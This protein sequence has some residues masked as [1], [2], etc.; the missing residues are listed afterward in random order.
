MCKLFSKILGE[1]VAF[2]LLEFDKEEGHS[3]PFEDAANN[4]SVVAPYFIGP[5][6]L[7]DSGGA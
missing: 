5:M 2:H 4:K 3:C 7:L 1:G 6:G